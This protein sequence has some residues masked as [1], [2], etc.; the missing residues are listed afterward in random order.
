MSSRQRTETASSTDAK[1]SSAARVYYAPD[2]DVRPSNT[3]PERWVVYNTHTGHGVTQPGPDGCAHRS[4][5][6][7][8]KLAREA[9]SEWQEQAARPKPAKLESRT[10]NSGWK[11]CSF[12]PLF[13]GK[14]RGKDEDGFDVVPDAAYRHPD[15]PGLV[16]HR[17]CEKWTVSHEGSGL[18]VTRFWSV[19]RPTRALACAYALALAPLAD[20]TVPVVPLSRKFVDAVRRLDWSAAKLE[21][22]QGAKRCR[23]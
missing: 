11:K 3:T 16:V 7:S 2:L 4:F 20:W 8:E 13:P 5:F 14:L 12:H 17:F 15:A 9:M 21:A 19:Q 23:T 1:E 22:M 18:G 6:R 10:K